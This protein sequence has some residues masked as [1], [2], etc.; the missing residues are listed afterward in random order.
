[1]VNMVTLRR[2]CAALR[3]NW[4]HDETKNTKQKAS[5][6]DIQDQMDRMQI[7]KRP[8]ASRINKFFRGEDVYDGV[9]E[10]MQEW[11][12]KY[13]AFISAHQPETQACTAPTRSLRQKRCASEISTPQQSKRHQPS[14]SRSSCSKSSRNSTVQ[15]H[16]TG[17]DA[18]AVMRAAKLHGYIIPTGVDNGVLTFRQMTGEVVLKSLDFIVEPL[19]QHGQLG[20]TR[21]VLKGVVV[22]VLGRKVDDTA[23]TSKVRCSSSRS[24]KILDTTH[25]ICN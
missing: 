2:K 5:G 10:G 18:E 19:S 11:H 4:V 17:F 25:H 21:L 13:T 23:M 7:I 24:I 9:L 20:G 22:N 12:D 8:V 15:C 16:S 6:M 14:S 3:I 1:M